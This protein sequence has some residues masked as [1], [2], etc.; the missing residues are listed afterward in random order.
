MD[1]PV[2]T[3]SLAASP[4]RRAFAVGAL[5][6]LGLMLVWLGLVSATGAVWARLALAGLG[7]LSLMAAE[8][9]RRA[10][11][12]GLRLDEAGL[13]DGDGRLLAA[14]DD[15]ARVERGA[16]ALRPSNGFLLHLRTPGPRGWAPGL[17]WRVGRRLGVGGVLPMRPA[18]AMAEAIAFHLARRGVGD[19][20][21]DGGGGGPMA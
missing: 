21:R 5:G 18:R 1:D 12:G 17:W 2:P 15:I 6:A 10:T 16:F 20:G 11:G 19:T 8:A 13:S 9:L 7:V 3:M 4:A 14:W